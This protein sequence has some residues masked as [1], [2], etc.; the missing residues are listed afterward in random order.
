MFRFFNPELLVKRIDCFGYR[1]HKSLK[2][3]SIIRK[4]IKIN[5]PDKACQTTGAYFAGIKH[6]K[7]TI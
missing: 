1:S 6:H 3:N 5:E 4:L 7:S 2:S